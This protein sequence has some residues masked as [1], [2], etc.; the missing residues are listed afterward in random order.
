LS[1]LND[2]SEFGF[3]KNCIS[4]TIIS[5]YDK[6][7]NAT[8]APIGVITADLRNLTLKIFK[9]SLTYKNL[10]EK[11]CGV[12]NITQDPILFHRCVFKDSNPDGRIPEEWFIHAENV[13]APRMRNVDVCLEFTS[14]ILDDSND[15]AVFNCRIE[16][17]DIVRLPF[18]RVYS[19][20]Y[21]SVIES[22][23]HAS[24]IEH[25]L[26]IDKEKAQKLI[27]LVDHYQQI[28]V[29]VAPNSIYSEIINDI[30]N[31][32]EEWKKP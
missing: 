2:L 23:I 24:R 6:D 9:S 18:I 12:V 19:R 30:K 32:I 27:D 13:D 25:Y 14:S 10:M 28:V 4:E 21:S 15:N 1:Q 31:R 7:R 29:K 26:S 11:K 5:T 22:L 17:I 8:A 20:V 16:K 3:E